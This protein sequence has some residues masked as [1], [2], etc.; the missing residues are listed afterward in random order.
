MKTFVQKV[1]EVAKERKPFDK[2]VKT[3]ETVQSQV[4]DE[5]GN[6]SIVY[7]AQ[8]IDLK[9]RFENVMASYYTL[10]NL[11]SNGMSELLQPTP[12]KT[13][14]RVAI[15]DNVE[16]ELNKMINKE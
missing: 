9:S 10:S 5:E 12:A 15:A 2:D 1:N 4:Q 11:L 16:N 6:I 7:T 3:Y 14:S 8:E 13:R